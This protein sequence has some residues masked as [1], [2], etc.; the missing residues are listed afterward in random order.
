[1]SQFVD[2]VVLKER[3]HAKIVIYELL[4]YETDVLPLVQLQLIGWVR[5]NIDSPCH[6][7]IA[8]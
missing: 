3:Q 1:M 5:W 6:Q 7:F 4:P 8:E 2:L